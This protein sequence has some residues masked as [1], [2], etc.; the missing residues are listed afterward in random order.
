MIDKHT[1]FRL[2]RLTLEADSAHGIHSGRGD[3]VH[4]VLLVRDANG[5]PA[6]PG[7]S[8]AGVLRHAFARRH[9][10]AS[11]NELFG[12]LDD[13]GR[14]SRLSVDWGLVHDAAN[15]PHEGL[16]D[17]DAIQRDPLLEFLVRDKPV[18]RQRVS[19]NHRGSAEETGKF[20]TTVIPA[21]VRYT[22]WLGCWC[23]D[24]VAS[25]APWERLLR[26]LAEGPLHVGH[27]T[28]SG[29]GQ[30]HVQRLD[31][32]RWNLRTPEGRDGYRARPRLRGEGRGLAAYAL[33]DGVRS[34]RNVAVT[35]ELRA[36]AGWRV[37]GGEYSLNPGDKDPDLVP[38]HEVRVSWDGD[39]AILGK[40]VYLVPGSALKGALRHRVAFHWRR[41]NRQWASDALQLTDE[42]PAVTQLFGT[43]SGD[44]GVA[45][46]IRVGDLYLDDAR[47]GVL[48]HNRIDR[49]TGGV[50]GGALFSEEVL[51]QTPLTLRVEID[52]ARRIDHL[53]RQALQCALVDLVQGRLPVGA[54]GSRGLGSFSGVAPVWSDHGAWLQAGDQESSEVAA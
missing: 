20:D 51:W 40:Q 19:L 3:N 38:Q 13:G 23:T 21:G 49:F 2:A 35:V 37:G 30:F 11:A 34:D 27:G 32:A 45:G 24:D 9:S 46:A 4:D 33:A 12:T 10:E 36:E 54:A 6:I 48:M 8:L 18:V 29:N 47:T 22:H 15:Q 14:I 25:A 52:A 50:I 17:A 42:C 41:I 16:L 43:A 44:S 53:T 7:S 28:H 39:H 31:V 5:L 1:V 26:L